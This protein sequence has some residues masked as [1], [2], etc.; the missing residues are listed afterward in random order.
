MEKLIMKKHF[1]VLALS[2]VF[3]A[4]AFFG[5]CISTREQ[6]PPPS[7]KMDRGEQLVLKA[8]VQYGCTKYLSNH[9]EHTQKANQLV[10]RIDL[11]LN[12]NMSVSLNLL[13]SIVIESIE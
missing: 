2:I 6:T 7:N 1:F 8:S 10:S 3:I 13:E 4:A 11:T 5:G 9:P 12:N